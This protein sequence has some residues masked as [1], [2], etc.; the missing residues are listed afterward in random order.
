MSQQK[1]DNRFLSRLSIIL[2]ITLLV[3]STVLLV[4]S[5]IYKKNNL[6][7]KDYYVRFTGFYDSDNS[8]Y[9]YYID[10]ENITFYHESE[11]DFLVIDD[12][13]KVTIHYRFFNEKSRIYNYD[14]LKIKTNNLYRGKLLN[15]NVELYYI[16]V[17][18]IKGKEI[19]PT[20]IIG[21]KLA[22]E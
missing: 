12:E 20:K 6:K 17:I 10:S 21:G 11:F 7:Y 9:V 3:F 13:T 14:K 4:S 1:N 18:N 8:D 19:K 5:S 15:G 2:A 16:K 22:Y